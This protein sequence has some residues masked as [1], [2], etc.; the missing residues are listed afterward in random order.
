MRG[1]YLRDNNKKSLGDNG[2]VGKVLNTKLEDLYSRRREPTSACDLP[3]KLFVT[4]SEIGEG[5][6]KEE[7]KMIW[8][9]SLGNS[10]GERES[11]LWKLKHD[12]K[13]S[14]DV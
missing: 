3:W 6:H 12:A 9:Q 10:V 13:V 4:S 8:R 2:S 5:L 11:Q 14:Q 1:T 7:K